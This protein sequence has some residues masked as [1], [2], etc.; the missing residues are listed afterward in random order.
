MSMRKMYKDRLRFY[1]K[2]L[3]EVILSRPYGYIWACDS[4]LKEINE[5]LAPMKRLNRRQL[6]YVLRLNFNWCVF[7]NTSKSVGTRYIFIRSRRSSI[8]KIIKR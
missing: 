8:K 3:D 5:G 1:C 2:L 7:K 4:L 6:L